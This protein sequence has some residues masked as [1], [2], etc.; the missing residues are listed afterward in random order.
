MRLST[1]LSVIATM[2]Q[3]LQ[4][5]RPASPYSTKQNRSNAISTFTPNPE[6]S[7]YFVWGMIQLIASPAGGNGK[8][9]SVSAT[10]V[11]YNC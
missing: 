6:M 7:G 10:F 5:E 4:N 11:E 1:C 2:R 8:N 3:R 9:E